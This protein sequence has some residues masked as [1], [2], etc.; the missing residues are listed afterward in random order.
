MPGL[1]KWNDV[2]SVH[3]VNTLYSNEK[4]EIEQG[5]KWKS[6]EMASEPV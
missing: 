6:Q 5:K 3:T 4:R 1:M 2:Q